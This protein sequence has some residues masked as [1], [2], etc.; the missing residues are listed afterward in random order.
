MRFP[1]LMLLL[2]ASPLSAQ[3]FQLHLYALKDGLPTGHVA[4]TPASGYNNQPAFT[5]DG[6]GLLFSSDRAGGQME[7]FH[8]ALADGTLTNLTN[9]PDESEFSPQPSGTEGAISYVVEQG[10]P[11]QSVW[12]QAPGQPRQRA[13]NSLIPA[14]YYAQRPGQ[15]TLLWARY[16]YHLYFEPWGERADE[17]HLVSANVGRSLH[18]IPHSQAFSFLHKR[19]DGSWVIT[20]FEPDSGAL[21]PL[22]AVDRRSEDYAWHPDGQSLWM[23][24][25]SELWRWSVAGQWQ[26]VADLGVGTLGRLAL[27]PDGRH[28]AVVSTP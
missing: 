10:V 12:V 16:G 11:H 6:E 2:A 8:Y 1:L 19:V 4:V 18:P 5:A 21:R 23:G 15:G 7:I 3:D 20:A 17:G 28:L 25:G 24:R 13:I 14:G 9:T 27:S 22:V 26:K